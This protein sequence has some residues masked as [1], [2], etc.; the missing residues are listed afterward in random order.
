MMRRR[1]MGR[2]GRPGL[3]GTIAR[4]AVIAGTASATVNAVDNRSAKKQQAAADEQT[5]QQQIAQQQQQ[6]D[7]LEAAQTG[8]APAVQAPVAAAPA[9]AAPA[10]G[11]GDIVSQIQQLASLRDS[12]V[13]SNEEFDAAKT[14]LLGS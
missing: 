12:G 10:A 5:Q 8:Q 7:Q 11:G 2:G 3:L 1:P 14:K 13:L 6:I 9:A 4:T